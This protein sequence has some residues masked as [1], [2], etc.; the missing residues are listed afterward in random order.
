MNSSNDLLDI[1]FSHSLEN[2]VHSWEQEYLCFSVQSIHF[3]RD[4]YGGC[5]KSSFTHSRC[6]LDF[7][8]R[9]SVLKFVS[10]LHHD[11][12]GHKKSSDIIQRN[13]LRI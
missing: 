12:N 1:H 8:N 3:N 4:D 5:I 11:R 6:F 7:R 9:Y 10:L 13:E 2:E